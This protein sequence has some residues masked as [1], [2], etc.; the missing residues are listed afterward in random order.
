MAILYKLYQDNREKSINKG[1]WYARAKH[2][3]VV[4]TNELIEDM[5]KLCTVTDA[6]I[7]AML[8]ALV[9]AMKSRLQNSFAVNL[10]GLGTFRIGLKTI[11]AET[12]KEFVPVKNVVGARMNFLP[13]GHRDAMHRLKRKF[14]SDLDVQILPTNTVDRNKKGDGEGDDNGNGGN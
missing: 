2:L 7:A 11:P 13:E 14:L 10:E 6:D 5:E 1:K 8:R 9:Y 12:A 3:R 4:S